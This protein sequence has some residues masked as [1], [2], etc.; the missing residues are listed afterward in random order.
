MTRTF[1]WISAKYSPGAIEFPVLCWTEND[2]L[3]VL[4]NTYSFYNGDSSK[5]FS[6]WDNLVS[7]YKIKFWAYQ[8]SLINNPDYDD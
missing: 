8:N 2:K 6:Y 5:K 1:E 7:K 4:K 3:M